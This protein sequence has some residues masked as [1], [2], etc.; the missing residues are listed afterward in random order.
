MSREASLDLWTKRP[1]LPF[2]LALT[3]LAIR[4]GA[5]GT[6]SMGKPHQLRS[7]ALADSATAPLAPDKVCGRSKQH[8]WVVTEDS[9]GPIPATIS[10]DEVKRL[11]PGARDVVDSLVPYAA[12]AIPGFDSKLLVAETEA[13]VPSGR[14]SV[15]IVRTPLVRT[16]QGLGVGSTL[17]GLRQRL[18]PM[19]V[20]GLNEQGFFAVP[21]SRR[22][23]RVQFR[24]DGFDPAAVP[25]GWTPADTAAQSDL[26]PGTARVVEI[27]VWGS[28]T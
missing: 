7:P 21:R 16:R 11:C 17:A 27:Q 8:P 28:P 5:H 2:T 10:L 24:L 15:I 6:Q 22:N 23:S 12:V 18:G 19:L 3:V 13:A 4:C 25:G 14:M 20:L 1:S 26:V 9:V